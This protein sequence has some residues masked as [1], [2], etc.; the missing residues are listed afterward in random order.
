MG[1]EMY[2]REYTYLGFYSCQIL[3]PGLS[4]VY[5]IEDLVYNNKNQGKLIRSLVLGFKEHDPQEV[6]DAVEALE[7]SLDVEKFIGVIFETSFT[8]REFKA[9][10]YLSLGA[11]TEAIG[12]LEYSTHPLSSVLL[13]LLRMQEAGC[14]YEEYQDGLEAIFGEEKVEKA[15]AIVEGKEYLVDTTF[16]GDYVNVLALYDKLGVKKHLICRAE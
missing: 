8:M 3:V 14:A 5:P 2:L 6:L 13:E 7:D 9:Q 16:H 12:L 4:E 1:K 10:I 11:Y 15:R